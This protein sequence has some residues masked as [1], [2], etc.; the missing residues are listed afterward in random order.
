MNH[1]RTSLRIFSIA[2]L[3]C[4]IV[5]LAVLGILFLLT[6]PRE[7]TA[8]RASG[9]T[10]VFRAVEET[11]TVRTL[12]AM[13]REEFEAARGIGPSLS[14]AVVALREE[15]G[16]FRFAEDLQAVNGIGDGKYQAVMELIS[17]TP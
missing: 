2:A 9:Q 5:S 15:M 14:E 1:R 12:N 4:L 7:G 8:F 11:D 3:V 10:G 16:G 6:C 17:G 13:T